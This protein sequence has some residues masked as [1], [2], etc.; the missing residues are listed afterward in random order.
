MQFI[1][2]GAWFL[3]S[4]D[5]TNSY[6]GASL[7]KRGVVVVSAN[8][9]LDVFGWL[10]LSELQAES[11]A[12]EFSNY[13][14]MDQQFALRWTRDNIA[15]FGGNPKDVTIFGGLGLRHKFSSFFVFS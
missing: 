7:A 14:L 12:K 11:P 10:A 15:S 13:G 5:F 2:G 1:H 8:Y 9:R 4:N 3:G 6:N